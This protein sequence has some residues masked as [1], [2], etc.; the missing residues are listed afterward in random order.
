MRV[1][2]LF[3]F[4]LIS[5]APLTIAGITLYLNSQNIIKKGIFNEL[6]I[7]GSGI[8]GKVSAF[9]EGKK[10]TTLNF[11]SDGIVKDGLTYYDPDDPQVDNL[12]KNTNF[13]L[14]KNKL[15]L[16]P[17]LED[18]LVLNLKGKVIFATNDKWQKKTNPKRLLPGHQQIP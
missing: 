16:D 8:E 9:I 4:V 2:L 17:Y 13:H 18:I 15:S 6:S 11:C 10:N 5:I 3:W 14:T 1:K 7:S 12:I